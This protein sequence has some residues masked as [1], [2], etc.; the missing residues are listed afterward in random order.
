MARVPVAV[1][2]AVQPFSVVVIVTVVSPLSTP[3]VLLLDMSTV[4]LSA[5]IIDWAVAVLRNLKGETR[6]S[7]T[8]WCSC[9][10]Y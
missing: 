5:V 10:D 8:N 4:P 6:R 9:R 2:M 7:V 3:V 1:E